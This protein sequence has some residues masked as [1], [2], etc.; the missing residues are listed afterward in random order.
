MAIPVIL[1]VEDHPVMRETLVQILRWAPVNTCTAAT[2]SEALTLLRQTTPDLT[3]LDMELP[4]GISGIDILGCVRNTPR[5]AA[6]PVLLHTAESGAVDLIE[7]QSADLVLLKPV[8]PDHL[9][10]LVHRLLGLP[11]EG[12][13][14]AATR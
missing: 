4:D 9:I 1:V 11:D 10:K 7:A 14:R 2:G 13:K 6:M 3:I 12:Q 8:D 5:L